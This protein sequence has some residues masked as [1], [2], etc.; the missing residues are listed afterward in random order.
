MKSIFSRLILSFIA[1]ILVAIFS[2]GIFFSGLLRNY[3]IK[4]KEV[5]LKNKGNQ[6]IELSR[7]F[8][9]KNIDENTFSYVLS[10]IDEIVNSRTFII[11]KSGTIVSSHFVFKGSST[12]P[13]NLRKGTKVDD[14][15]IANIF[16]GLTIVKNGYSAYFN[17]PMITVG[18]PIYTKSVNP[19][20]INPVVIG[21]VILNSPVTG[22]SEAVN[23]TNNVLIFASLGAL[24]FSLITA[25]FLSKTLSMPIHTISRAALDIA[26]GNYTRKVDINRKDEIGNLASA[27]N[28][29]TEK[30][31]NTVG[32]L[33]N[34]KSKLSDILYSME[35]GLIA[36]DNNLNIIHINPAVVSLFNSSEAL[37][38][39]TF[40]EL[41]KGG[42]VT[43]NVRQVLSDGKSTS[44][45][46]D[47]GNNRVVNI[48]VSP[49]KYQDGR[50][51]GAIILLEDI[52]ESVKLENMRRDFVANVSHELRTPLTSIRGFIEPLIDGTV[53]DD[54]TRL[55]Y[56]KIIRNETLRLERLIN[57]LLDLS[58]FQAGKVTLDIQRVN[59]VELI[60]NISGKFQPLLDSKKISFRFNKTPA[61]VY[62]AADGDR[63]EQLMVI[64]ID[65][66]IKFTPEGGSIEINLKEEDELVSIAIK[67]TG[68]GIP[69]E[70]IPF[71][72]D[73]FYKVDKSRTDKNSGTGLG[74]SIAKN[75]IE[76]HGQK[77]IV[78][79]NKGTGT[80]FEF[81]M[82]K[83]K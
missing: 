48:I 63:I 68:I 46:K 35:E 44:C 39:I 75:I 81:T 50:I 14:N 51:Y 12:P 52:S 29:L 34:E 47:M 26:H 5:E 31:N 25:Y 15:D 64:F 2:I 23:K 70:D 24:A 10:S 83:E 76:L 16:S 77:V 30:L 20:D 79:S 80:S 11:D 67:D 33:N 19:G 27:F 36:V 4:Q 7:D 73:R 54:I 45:E 18:M 55:K 71:I 21:A 32:D 40:F 38:G 66:A 17:E 42:E 3:L 43:A 6:V 69:K 59:I 37:S 62:I 41:D 60:S 72:W 56:H 13:P 22:V 49:L 65:N 58:R 74:L 57:D 78:E 61:P 8:L 1:I 28:Y 9:N 82:K 53:D